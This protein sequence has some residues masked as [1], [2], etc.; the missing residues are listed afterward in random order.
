MAEDRPPPCHPSASPSTADQ[1]GLPSTDHM[2]LWPCE[3]A[4]EH[5]AEEL[6]MIRRTLDLWFDHFQRRLNNDKFTPE[7]FP[8][9]SQLLET[10]TEARGRDAERTGRRLVM[11]VNVG[12]Q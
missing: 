11:Q 1:E 6:R 5:I 8:K 3:V 7:C 10:L 9:L 2:D 4:Y 12:H